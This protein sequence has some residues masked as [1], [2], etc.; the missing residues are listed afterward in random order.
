MSKSIASLAA[1]SYVL[2]I[3]AKISSQKPLTYF[4]H[5]GILTQRER[6]F[7]ILQSLS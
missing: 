3:F 2:H 1:A 5:L 6:D 7:A 4:S